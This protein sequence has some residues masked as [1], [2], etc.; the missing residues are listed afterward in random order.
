MKKKGQALAKSLVQWVGASVEDATLEFVV[1]LFFLWEFV[2]CG[3][4]Q[5]G[6]RIWMDFIDYFR[7]VGFMNLHVLDS[8]LLKELLPNFR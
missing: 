5:E 8:P 7:S 2:S 4:E 6:S 3:G 1:L